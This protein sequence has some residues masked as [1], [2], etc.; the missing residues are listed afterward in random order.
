[1]PVNLDQDKDIVRL[2][3]WIFNSAH[4]IVMNISAATKDSGLAQDCL[5]MRVLVWHPSMISFSRFDV[6]LY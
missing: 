5:V 1:M 4:L 2:Q 3:Y 6:L